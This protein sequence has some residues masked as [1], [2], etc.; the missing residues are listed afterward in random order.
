M[1]HQPRGDA[2]IVITDNSEQFQGNAGGTLSNSNQTLTI[3]AASIINGLVLN[4]ALGDDTATIDL[5]T[6][7]GIP[8]TFDGG[9]QNS[10]DLLVLDDGTNTYTNVTHTFIDNSSGSITADGNTINYTGLEPVTDNLDAANRVFTFGNTNQI[11]T[12]GDN[13]NGTMTIDSDVGGEATTFPHP[14]GSL[15][16]NGGTADDTFDINSFDFIYDADFTIDGNAGTDLVNLSGGMILSGT[17]GINISAD[18]INVLD[19]QIVAGSGS[20]T[21]T[22]DNNISIV[23]SLSAN[24]G[25]IILTASGTASGNYTGVSITASV[26]T[27]ATNGG[28][29]QIS[30]I[31]GD[32]A[33]GSQYG[34]FIISAAVLGRSVQITGVGGA[35][36]GDG[37]Y[38]VCITGNSAV[39]SISNN[40]DITATGGGDGLSNGNT[41]LVLNS[42]TIAA[43]G[44]GAVTINA[45]GAASIGVGNDGAYIADAITSIT[46][47]N[48]AIT[49]NAFAPADSVGLQFLSV[50]SISTGTNNAITILTDSYLGD[51]TGSI[52]SGTGTTT[53]RPFTPG[54]LVDLGGADDT[55]TIITPT[56]TLGLDDSELDAITAGTLVLGHSSAGDMTVSSDISLPFQTNLDLRSGGTIAIGTTVIPGGFLDSAGGD[57]TF[58]APN[59]SSA[60]AGNDVN[61]A[62]GNVTLGTALTL[63]IA[64]TVVDTDYNQL[65]VVGTIDLNNATLNLTG[66]Y[67]PDN[68][69]LAPFLPPDGITDIFT[70]ID[71]DGTDPVVG[72]FNGLPQGSP[73]LSLFNGVQ[74]YI[75]YTGNDG[76]DVVLTSFANT[77]PIMFTEVTSIPLVT[78]D[79]VTF[80]L[81]NLTRNENTT[82]LTPATLT[83]LTAVDPDIAAF[84]DYITY[85]IDPTSPDFLAFELVPGFNTATLQF[86]ADY[87]DFETPLDDGNDNIYEIQVFAIDAAGGK[88]FQVISIDVQNIE[89]NACL[90][91]GADGFSAVGE[92]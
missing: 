20:I 76:N 28:A 60:Y 32:D 17:H 19:Q 80:P 92:F 72:T 91:D 45:T 11:I 6:A 37:N 5:A 84:G 62:T 42:A 57:V 54:V 68:D 3:P 82:P 51:G 30:G 81:V 38:G 65:N 13:F 49:I 74:L 36:I 23:D 67:V 24:T 61:A 71:N 88:A 34:V 26:T 85:T 48:G 16:I 2:N 8:V 52:S 69:I 12:L 35:S 22:A 89:R 77:T 73:L 87:G 46:T 31:G 55:E 14:T 29:V 70:L 18:E 40:I 86:K 43:G 7:L 59:V 1:E 63:D 58:T 9:L 78:K 15:T 25:D 83:T 41:G 21:L 75:S 53:I 33:S 66:A 56:L 90:Y 10:T 64:G 50:A 27:D 39:S 79:S 4:G 47:T 44:A